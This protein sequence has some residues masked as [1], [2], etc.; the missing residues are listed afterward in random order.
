VDEQASFE[1]RAVLAPTRARLTRL[2]LLLPVVALVAVAWAGV[3]GTPS[4]QTTAE[5]TAPTAVIA[6]SLPTGGSASPVAV[7]TPRPQR[8]ALA[9]GLDVQRL[10]EVGTRSFSRDEIVVL[11]GW[12]VPMAIT[13]CPPMDAI[14]RDGE[15]PELRGD[16]DTYAFCRRSGLLYAAHPDLREFRFTGR[17]AIPATLVTGVIAPLE[18]E[19]VGSRATEVVFIGRLFETLEGCRAPYGC[20]PELLIDHVAWTAAGA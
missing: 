5:V 4:G 3:S 14:Y 19:L 9:L 8:P 11:T 15:L 2:A 20:R 6:S 1:T 7:E 10:D 12:Y 16:V 17:L 18:I 13:D